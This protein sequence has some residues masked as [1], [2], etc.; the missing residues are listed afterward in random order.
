MKRS[1][2]KNVAQTNISTMKRSTPQHSTAQQS[3]P[4]IYSIEKLNAIAA[5]YCVY[6]ENTIN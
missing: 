1:N 6:C 5:V 3:N 2:R 4:F